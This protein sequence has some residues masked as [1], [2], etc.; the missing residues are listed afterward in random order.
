MIG[1]NLDLLLEDG[2]QAEQ[3]RTVEQVLEVTG[4]VREMI[5][6]MRDYPAIGTSTPVWTD[7]RHLTEQAAA[8]VALGNVQIENL[9]LIIEMLVDLLVEKVIA[10]LFER[11]IRHG[12]TAS[13]IKFST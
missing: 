3:T 1:G 2:M 6:F 7:L 5:A 8:E 13:K 4:R 12:K 9:L 11:A 10:T